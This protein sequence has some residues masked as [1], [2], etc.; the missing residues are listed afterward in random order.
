MSKNAK[1][2]ISLSLAM[3]FWAFSFVW[4]KQ[5][6][7]SFEPFTVVFF[8]LLISSVLLYVVLKTIGQLKSMRKHDLKWFALLAFF[9]PFMYFMGESFGLKYVSSTVGAVII[10]TIPLFAPIVDRLF[11]RTKITWLN[12]SGII[13]SFAGVLM[14]ILEKDLTLK[15]PLTGILLLFVAVFAALGYTVVLK[16]IP[17]H[18]N[19]VS[20]ITY[21][22]MI[23]VFYFL[24]MFLLFDFRNIEISEIK[25]AAYWSVLQLAVFASSVA[26]IFFTWSI[27]VIGITKANVFVN[28]IPVFTA[29]FAW[30]LLDE[31]LTVKKFIGIVIVIAGVFISQI[32]KTPVIIGK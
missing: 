18:Y 31:Q 22:N 11:F 9:E 5:A 27:R 7:E 26:F 25:P 12:L 15:A 32:K 1:V 30:W 14:I 8:R 21:Q 28:M 17:V 23:G 24:P 10:S 29:V 3:I 20:I 16:K 19:A 2:F 6:Y 4:V 13:I